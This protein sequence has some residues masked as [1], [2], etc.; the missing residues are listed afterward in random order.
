[1]E[2]SI[3]TDDFEHCYFCGRMKQH[4]HHVMNAA[5]KKKSEKYGLMIPVC[6]LCHDKI[7]NNSTNKG[8][9]MLVVRRI[10]QNKFEELYSRELWM[11]EFKKNYL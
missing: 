7:H 11:K 1:M 5:N 2:K 8:L 10:G 6:F 9:N 4:T 3:I